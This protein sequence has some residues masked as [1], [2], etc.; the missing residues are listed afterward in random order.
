[1]KRSTA[2]LL[3]GT[4]LLSSLFAQNSGVSIVPRI[5]PPP[6]PGIANPAALTIRVNTDLILV[7]V[8]VTDRKNYLVTGLGKQNFRLYDD[9]VEQ[10]ISHF[11][12]EDA[13]IS[14]AL[15]VDTSSSMRGK[16][17]ASRM[18]VTEFLL[19]A[20]PGDDF[21]LIEFNDKPRVVVS[22][23]TSQERIRNEFD[24]LMPQGRTALLDGVVAALDEMQ[25]ARHVR[26]AL[27]VISDGGDNH[28]RYDERDLQQR[29]QEADVQLY[30]IGILDEPVNP[31][32]AS[33]R[34][35]RSLLN[36]LAKMSGGRLFVGDDQRKLIDIATSIGTV[37][38]NQYMLGYTPSIPKRDGRFHKITVKVK[39]AA[40]SSA[41]RATFRQSY[42]APLY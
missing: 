38:R 34:D 30:S 24:A 39:P 5:P 12:A 27:L 11:A 4:I 17:Q 15:V 19:A 14:I 9:G 26:K 3:S 41:L 25:Y 40:D 7:P 13:P 18:A 6:S 16:L 33:P 42:L 21:A 2:A 36:R 29:M 10:N 23:T 31:W 32:G 22:F 35:A 28:S 37:L 20:D 1:M 8:S